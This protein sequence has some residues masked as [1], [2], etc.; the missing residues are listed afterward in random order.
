MEDKVKQSH[1]RRHSL[2]DLEYKHSN[3]RPRRWGDFGNIW[4]IPGHTLYRDVITAGPRP[5]APSETGAPR[6]RLRGHGPYQLMVAPVT[7]L[8][9]SLLPPGPRLQTR[10]E[11]RILVGS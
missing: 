3:L 9:R 5:Q 11:S 2:S 10:K 8:G 7:G 6:K 1:P 4:R